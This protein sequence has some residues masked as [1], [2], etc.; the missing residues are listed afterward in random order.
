MGRM[1]PA[2]R[3][4]K[5]KAPATSSQVALYQEAAAKGH[6]YRFLHGERDLES[7]EVVEQRDLPLSAAYGR[8]ALFLRLAGAS[9]RGDMGWQGFARLATFCVLAAMWVW[10]EWLAEEGWW[11]GRFWGWRSIFWGWAIKLWYFCGFSTVPCFL[12]NSWNW[13]S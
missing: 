9:E 4:H 13:R 2:M 6:G 3:R 10:A 1:G 12:K 7:G 8:L 11:T 5:R